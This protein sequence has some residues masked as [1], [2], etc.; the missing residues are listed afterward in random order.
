MLKQQQATQTEPTDG[1]LQDGAVILVFYSYSVWKVLT[2]SMISIC[3]SYFLLPALHKN[4]TQQF[5]NS[6]PHT[7]FWKRKKNYKKSR[8][9]VI[10]T[11]N[12]LFKLSTD[13]NTKAQL[14]NCC[15]QPHR[16]Q[17]RILVCNIRVF[18]DC[19]RD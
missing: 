6:T 7:H 13:K 19:N 12:Y 11:K 9:S 8:I 17:I 14:K 10:N 5:D 1:F 15:H 2:I 16:K 18:S 4:L 3:S